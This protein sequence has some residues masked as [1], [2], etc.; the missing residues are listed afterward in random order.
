MTQHER[1]VKI[2]K[3]SL[4]NIIKR[5][6]KL[7]EDIKLKDIRQKELDEI[8]ELIREEKEII[9]TIKPK[10]IIKKLIHKITGE[11]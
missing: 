10:G 5:R 9:K 7:E 1:T 6:K 3:T 2:R 8:K 4:D 11:V